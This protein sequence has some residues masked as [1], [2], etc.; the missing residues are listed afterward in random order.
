NPSHL[1]YVNTVVLGR[2]RAK[3]DRRGDLERESVMPVLIHG[4]GAFIGQGIVQETLNLSGLEGYRVGG[5]LHVVVN[6]QIGFTTGPRQARSTTYATDVAKM[7]QSPIFHVNGEDPE[8]VAQVVQLA[9]DFRR[10]FKRDV[11]IDMYCYRRLGHNETDEPAFTQPVMYGKV[12]KRKSVREAYRDQ[13]LALGEVTMAEAEQ[14]AEDRRQRL[15][16]HL[17]EARKED[18]KLVYSTLQGVWR[19]Y[20]GGP[21]VEVPDVETA[22]S[23]E[24][25]VQWLEALTH[26][27][28]GF[29]LNPKLK[30]ALAARLEMARG[31]A[32]LDWAAG[33]ALAFASLVAEG[34]RV[35]LTG[36]DSERGTFS[37]RHAVF[38]DTEDGHEHV[39][40][41]ELAARHGSVFEV[42]NSPL[43][44]AGVLGFEYGYSVDTPDG[45]VLWEAQFGDFANGAQVIIDQ[46]LSSAEEKWGR[47]SGLVMLL[48]H[49]FEGQ[50]PEHSSARLERYLQLCAEDNMQVAYPTTPAQY[51]HLLRRQ[52]LRPLR[53]PLIVMTPKSL[54]RHPQAVS[55]LD[56]FV[57]G[58]F[59]RVIP[60]AQ[61]DPAGVR[62]VLLTTGKLYY[63]LAAAR[64]ER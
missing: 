61:V 62:R 10:E 19:D 3:Q 13:L 31:N 18:F 30:R 29:T 59:Q 26:V 39:P 41:A 38:H 24:Q 34:H 53:K 12:R 64:E 23:R 9:M 33:E 36:Q 15:E 1:E 32:P 21:D 52:V 46:F 44:E 20:V 56:E 37:H 7:L 54:L 55:D 28:E 57:S 42:H 5:A 35:R 8:A 40:L 17:S 51:F 2:T 22:V 49:G 25:A 63:E 27:P 45:L 48:P 47:L 11:V 6:N 4:D 50:G 43:S 16:A 60:D 14:I 58:R